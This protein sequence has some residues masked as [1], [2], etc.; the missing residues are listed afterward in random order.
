MMLRGL[1]ILHRVSVA[2][3]LRSDANQLAIAIFEIDKRWGRSVI[4]HV[5]G[6]RKPRRISGRVGTRKLTSEMESRRVSRLYP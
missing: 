5:F 4:N 2:Q 1:H 6:Q 3:D